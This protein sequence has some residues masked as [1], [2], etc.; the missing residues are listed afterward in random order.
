[1]DVR[2]SMIFVYIIGFDSFISWLLR[3]GSVNITN[4]VSRI[5]VVVCNLF[6]DRVRTVSA[7]VSDI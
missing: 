5:S 3:I 2:S 4:E 1:M 6:R 7:I